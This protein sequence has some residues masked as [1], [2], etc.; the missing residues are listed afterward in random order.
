M[1]GL[2]SSYLPGGNYMNLGNY[3]NFDNLSNSITEEELP[4]NSINDTKY[5][6]I[7]TEEAESFF[8]I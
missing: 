1:I 2:S 8:N 7:N 4:D 5:S 3:N 6:E